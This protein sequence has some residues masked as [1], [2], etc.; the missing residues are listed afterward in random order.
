MNGKPITP[1]LPSWRAGVFLMLLSCVG[2]GSSGSP[3]DQA[4][5]HKTLVAALD[6]WKGGEKPAS[7][8][9]RTPPISVSDGD[10]T[11]GERLQSYHAHDKGKLVGTDIHFHVAIEVKTAKGKVVKKDAVYAVA[12]HPQ[13]MVL[14]QDD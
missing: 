11:S 5:G 6:A 14:R 3:S 13:L 7:L 1:R 8:T 9:Q 10:W 4:E 12:T 2:C